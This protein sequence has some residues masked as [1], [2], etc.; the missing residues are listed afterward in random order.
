MK[1]SI[2]VPVYN[3]ER[4]VAECLDS[5]LEQGLSDS[6]YEILCVDDGST[7]RSGGIA[8]DYARRYRQVAVIH[9]GNRGLSAAR[10]TGIRAAAGEYVYFID[11]DDLLERGVLIRDCS[12]YRGLGPG[13]YRAAVRTHAENVRLLETIQEVLHGKNDHGT[14]HVL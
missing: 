5:L 7:D 11:S 14:G 9:Q 12:N 6:D 2:V 8:E 3:V 13:W 1:L 10:N 4:Y